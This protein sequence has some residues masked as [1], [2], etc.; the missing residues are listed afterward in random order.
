M[1]HLSGPFRGLF[2]ALS[3]ASLTACAGSLEADASQTVF[4]AQSLLVA[5]DT[6][7]ADYKQGLYG[8]P[9][10]SVVAKLNSLEAEAHTELDPLVT[11][12]QEGAAIDA[13]KADAAEAAAEAFVSY[14]STNGVS[15]A[16][17]L[18]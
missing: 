3:L 17:A 9:N 2:L 1:T 8:A 7:G 4:T 5:A 16:G 13:V 15:A 14:L 11:A 12:A 6:A 18:K 10:A